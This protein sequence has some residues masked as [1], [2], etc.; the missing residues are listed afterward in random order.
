MITGATWTVGFE[1]AVAGSSP[2]PETAAVPYRCPAAVDRGVAGRRS[3]GGAHSVAA[4]AA[5]SP[6]LPSPDV[7]RRIGGWAARNRQDQLGQ[8]LRSS[9]ACWARETRPRYDL[10]GYQG[11]LA[12]WSKPSMP[13]M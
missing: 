13:S 11:M 5:R 3:E 2:G 10:P 8:G 1:G 12:I 4:P 6:G 9:I 7:S